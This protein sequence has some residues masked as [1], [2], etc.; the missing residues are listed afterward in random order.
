MDIHYHDANRKLRTLATVTGQAVDTHPS[1]PQAD[2][3]ESVIS[4][5][6]PLVSSH[7]ISN[8]WRPSLRTSRKEPDIELSHLQPDGFNNDKGPTRQQPTWSRVGAFEKITPFLALIP[9]TSISVFLLVSNV[10]RWE[11]SDELHGTIEKNRAI[12][13][14]A[15][16]VISSILALLHLFVIGK[17]LQW[18]L[19]LHLTTKPMSLEALQFWTSMLAQQWRP[20][21]RWRFLLPL[22]VFILICLGPA[23]LWVGALTP[24]TAE[25]S[26]EAS[27]SLPSYGNTEILL[28]NW[29]QRLG[30]QSTRTPRGFFTYNVGELSTGKII[31]TAASA[32]TVDGSARRHSKM[33]NTGYFYNGRS[34]GVGVSIGLVDD[35]IVRNQYV[36]N[37]TFQEAGYKAISTCIHNSTTDYHLECHTDS[38][39]PYCSALGRLPN[40]LAEGFANYPS[41]GPGNIVAVA[42][43]SDPTRPGRMLGIAAG[44]KYTLLNTT[45]CELQFVP[46]LFNI[47]VDPIGKTIE[48]TPLKVTGISDIE[49]KGNLTF[50]AN[51]QYT[52]IASD[53]TNLYS[54]LIGNAMYTN[55]ENY[56]ISQEATGHQAGSESDVALRA[57]EESFDASMDDILSGYAA[58]QLMGANVTQ[59]TRVEV[60]RTVLRLGQEAWILTVLVLNLV[61]IF[62]A[63]EEAVRTRCW[64]DLDEFDFTDLRDMVIGT[65]QGDVK[66]VIETI[67]STNNHGNLLVSRRGTVLDIHYSGTAGKKRDEY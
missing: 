42:V 6:D 26:R 47:T 53:Q 7:A 67:L 1:F 54:S 37:Y 50:L 52:L 29:T 38:T 27:L 30:L 20:T 46:T 8:R 49:P 43:T 66:D 17:L 36:T 19:R 44:S 62:A 35:D 23:A 15:V 12:T 45:Q 40:S 34:Y 55:I 41:W 14:V 58:A 60:Y 21:L 3:A 57:L 61:L 13:Q 65:A 18:M 25:G 28:S 22:A 48:V 9:T 39:F 24:V 5:V 16:Q 10:K 2:N 31:E 4:E 51:W 33:D 56:K 11:L 64:K 32:T 63:T 59:E